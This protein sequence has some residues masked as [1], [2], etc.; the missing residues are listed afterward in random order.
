MVVQVDGLMDDVEVTSGSIQQ[1]RRDLRQ[2][3]ARVNQTARKGQIQFMETGLEVEAAKEVVL[4][5]VEELAGNLSQHDVRL[6]E[7]DSDLDYLYSIL[8]KHNSS[9][10]CDCN[11]LKAAVTRLERGVANVTELANENRLA[12]EETGGGEAGPWGG[13]SNWEPAVQVLQHDL[14]QVRHQKTSTGLKHGC[15]G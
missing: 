14:Q 9:A 1:L 6:Q 5:R 13:A 8:Y 15:D 7:A 2:L 12:L 11:A 10:D 4:R 3:D